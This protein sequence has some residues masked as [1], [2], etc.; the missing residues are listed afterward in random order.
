MFPQP[1]QFF[2]GN[3]I[4][5]FRPRAFF[6][7]IRFAR[8]NLVNCATWCAEF[9]ALKPPKNC[10]AFV[11]RVAEMQRFSRDSKKIQK[12]QMPRGT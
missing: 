12:N 3:G 11:T 4:A 9:T 7:E 5:Y 6:A 10:Y 1:R 2:H 8:S